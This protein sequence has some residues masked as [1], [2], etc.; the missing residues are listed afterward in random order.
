VVG[1][2]GVDRRRGLRIYLASPGSRHS[3]HIDRLSRSPA[4]GET[5]LLD[6]YDDERGDDSIPTP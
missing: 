1:R 3:R 5:L 6:A 4:S 2:G